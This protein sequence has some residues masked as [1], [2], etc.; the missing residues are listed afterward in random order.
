MRKKEIFRYVRLIVL[1]FI[2]GCS[3]FNNSSNR[4]AQIMIEKNLSTV[5]DFLGDAHSDTSGFIVNAISFFEILTEIQSESDANMFGKMNPTEQDYE[6]WK[7]W[8]KENKDNVFWNNK[9]GVVEV[10][11]QHNEE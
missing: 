1:F 11:V 8:Y 5:K 9:K 10:R 7:N 6:N 3:F 2:T 4:K